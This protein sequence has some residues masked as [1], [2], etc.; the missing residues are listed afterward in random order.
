MPLRHE[1][2]VSKAE[3]FTTS[4]D[5]WTQ[6]CSIGPSGFARYARLFHPIP[7]DE[8]SSD[9]AILRNHE[10]DLDA[11]TLRRLCGILAEHTA[12]PEECYFGL[13]EGFGDI[14][15]GSSV[16]VAFRM[17]EEADLASA[18]T[19][20]PAFPPE[21]IDGPRVRIPARD[22]LLFRGPLGEAGQWGAADLVPGWSRTINSPNLIWPADR[23]WFVATEIDV[24]WTGVAGSAALIEALR[25]DAE[26][27]VEEVVPSGEL[28]YW[29]NG[30]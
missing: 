24:P 8:D 4:D 26:L 3:W 23:A 17:D 21:V 5:P 30:T 15:G 2:D 14:Y 25:E 9:L 13:W 12:T 7:P 28:S 29:R 11:E 22:Y 20:G 27:D 18:P 19:V 1:P 6:L 10:G 16:A